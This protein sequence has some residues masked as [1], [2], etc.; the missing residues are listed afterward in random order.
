MTASQ[1]WPK[2]QIAE[3]L[4]G[5][6]PIVDVRAPIEFAEGA[7]P[8]STNLPILDNEQR[9][10]VGTCYKQSGRE[11]ALKLGYELVSGDNK[12]K[13][14]EAWSQV[15]RHHSS[16]VI[17]CFRGGLRSQIA[18]TWLGEIG[19]HK[20]RL[21][22]GYKFGRNF[23]SEIIQTQSGKISLMVVSGAT[24]AGKSLLLQEVSKTSQVIDLEGMAKHRGSAFGGFVHPQST[25]IDFENQLG[26]RLL[27]LQQTSA[28]KIFIE[29]ESRMIGKCAQPELLF[30]NLR[31]SP[32]VVI[33]EPIECRI[34]TTFN[35]YILGSPVG[36]GISQ[37]GLAIFASFQKSLFSISKRL[38]GLRYSE[39]KGDLLNSEK[40]YQDEF[41][42]ASNRIWIEKLLTYYYDPLYQKSLDK[43]SN[44]IIFKGN[45]QEVFNFLKNNTN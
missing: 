30:N 42:L 29:D 3:L 33:D 11:A 27:E 35:E 41:N 44:S 43:K 34:E 7:L 23:L 39:V 5:K 36:K 1:F 6:V 15:F 40:H 21:E 28:N 18:Q 16:A 19:I 22:G 32:L 20:Q 14:I 37:D 2:A 26:L 45:R 4:L 12:L 25:Q 38:G 13:K 9:A 17:T 10:Q 8:G 24:G 31:S